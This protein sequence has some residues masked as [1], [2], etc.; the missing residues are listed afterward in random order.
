MIASGVSTG[1]TVASYTKPPLV[2]NQS[3]SASAFANGVVA[4]AVTAR[5]VSP[6]SAG[7]AG[8]SVNAAREAGTA[9]GGA[10]LL[11]WRHLARGRRAPRSRRCTRGR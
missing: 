5:A 10:R 11:L 6:I 8:S 9:I 1:S 4:V 2:R 3:R 7:I